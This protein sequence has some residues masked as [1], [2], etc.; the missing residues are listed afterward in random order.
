MNKIKF[1]S[2]RP[3]LNENSSSK[4]ESSTKEIPDWY[5]KADRFVK[6][7]VGNYVVGPDTGKIPTWKSCP[8]LLDIFS[9]GYVLK[10]PT[11]LEFYI[12]DNNEINVKVKDM[13]KQ[14]FCTRRGK[15]PEFMHPMGYHEEHFAWWP[16]WAVEL[17][18]GYSALYTHPLN[19]F[20]LP[21]L[22]T[23]GV[24]DND[25]VNLPGSMPFFIVKGFTGIIPEGTPYA[26]VIPFKREDWESEIVIESPNKLVKKNMD[27]SKKYR[28]PNGGVYKNE[29]W[30]MRKYK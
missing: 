6:D 25:K 16:D 5:R 10:T 9:T 22:M 8:A 24:V 13:Y 30:S 14:D 21:F 26:Q 12:D 20:D 3:W 15:M 11:D 17:P 27:N 19:R 23:A 28:I 2:N 4:P 7:H 18:E 1:V 29:V